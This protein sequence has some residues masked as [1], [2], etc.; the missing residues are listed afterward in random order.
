MEE[1]ANVIKTFVLQQQEQDF[2][3]KIGTT[4]S[5]TAG[6]FD[7]TVQVFGNSLVKDCR[8]K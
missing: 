4:F 1:L 6:N 5:T 2:V 7:M 3:K 8:R